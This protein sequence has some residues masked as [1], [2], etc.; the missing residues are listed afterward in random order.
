METKMEQPPISITFTRCEKG[1]DVWLTFRASTGRV[2][3]LSVAALAER[4]GPI[5][6]TALR[7]WGSDQIEADTTEKIAAED[8]AADR[9]AGSQ[10]GMGA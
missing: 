2:A 10:F 5:T 7:E 3:S 4:L 6:G 8:A 9:H 1:P